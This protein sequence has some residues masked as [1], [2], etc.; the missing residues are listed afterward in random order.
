MDKI[1]IIRFMLVSIIFL[2]V[3]VD[4]IISANIKNLRVDSKAAD[5]LHTDAHRGGT[6]NAQN[7][8]VVSHSKTKLKHANEADILKARVNTDP[9]ILA[10]LYYY[11]TSGTPS[12]P[13]GDVRLYGYVKVR[14]P[15]SRTSSGAYKTIQGILVDVWDQ[16]SGEPYSDGYTPSGQFIISTRTDS[17]GAFCVV[18]D[19]FDWGEL[20]NR[21]PVLQFYTDISNVVA[22]YDPSN[23]VYLY[24]MYNDYSNL[25]GGAYSLYIQGSYWTDPISGQQLYKND[26]TTVSYV[27]PPQSIVYVLGGPAGEIML[28]AML[29]RDFA[30][31]V[32]GESS[33]PGLN[34]TYPAQ[35]SV[36][37]YNT[38]DKRLWAAAATNYTEFFMAFAQFLLAQRSVLPSFERN[39]NFNVHTDPKTAW[40]VGWSIFLSEVI[41]RY[42]ISS[43]NFE[44]RDLETLYDSDNSRNDFDVASSVAAVLWDLYDSSD[45]DQDGD[46]IGDSLSISISDIWYVVRTYKPTTIFEFINGLLSWRT[47]LSRT[48][49]WELCWEHGINV[50]F[51]PPTKPEIININPQPSS[52]KWYNTSNVY[53]AWS[54]STDSMSGIRCYMVRV[55][56]YSSGSL[57]NWYGPY[58]Q[59]YATIGLPSGVWSISVVAVD[60][61]GNENESARKGPIQIDTIAPRILSYSP[62][63]GTVFLDNATNNIVLSVVCSDQISGVERVLI[64]YSYGGTNWSDWIVASYIS[65]EFRIVISASEWKPHVGKKLYWE[66]KCIDKAGNAVISQRFYVELVDDDPNPPEIVFPGNYITIYDSSNEDLVIWAVITDQESGVG[67]VTF[68]VY[69]QKYNVAITYNNNSI[70]WNGNTAYIIIPR[71]IWINY[72]GSAFSLEVIAYDK[73]ND[74]QGDA[75]VARSFITYGEILDDDIDG[76]VIHNVSVSEYLSSGTGD[77]I[78]EADEGLS[79]RISVSDPSGVNETIVIKIY[80]IVLVKQAQV[81]YTNG[82][83]FELLLIIDT[84]LRAGDCDIEITIYDL[85]NDRESDSSFSVYCLRLSIREEEVIFSFN[86][87]EINAL[88]NETITIVF[89]AYR[90]DGGIIPLEGQKVY[91]NVYNSS[92]LMHTIEIYY[93]GENSQV[94]VDLASLHAPAGYLRLEFCL[95]DTVFKSKSNIVWVHVWLLTSITISLSTNSPVWSETVV[96]QIILV[97]M[98][99]DPVSNAYVYL[100]YGGEILAEGYTDRSGKAIINWAVNLPEGEYEIRV[101]F[102][103]D[104]VRSYYP[105]EI[106]VAVSVSKAHLVIQ[107]SDAT[108]VFSDGGTICANVST[109]LGVPVNAYAEVYVVI[110]DDIYLLGGNYSLSGRLVVRILSSSY[111]KWLTPGEYVYIIMIYESDKFYEASLARNLI[112]E[113]DVLKGVDISTNASIIEWGDSLLIKIHAFDDDYCSIVQGIANITIVSGNTVLC[114]ILEVKDGT[115]VLS[116]NTNMFIPLQ[117]IAIIVKV[118]SD[119]YV[120]EACYTYYV[121]VCKERA[122]VYSNSYT[123]T[124]TYQHSSELLILLTD[125]DGEEVIDDSGQVFVVISGLYTIYN[126]TLKPQIR[127]AYPFY[128]DFLPGTYYLEIQLMSNFYELVYSPKI[129]LVIE[130]IST[131]IIATLSPQMVEYGDFIEIY[132]I[133]IDQDNKTLAGIPISI[134]LSNGSNVKYP[135]VTT[136]TD[137]NGTA[138]IIVRMSFKPGEYVLIIQSSATSIHASSSFET[139]LTILEEDLNAQVYVPSV[140]EIGNAARIK[141]YITDNDNEPVAG[142]IVSIIVGD[143]LLVRTIYNGPL[144]IIW[145]PDSHG[146]HLIKVEV[147]GNGHYKDKSLSKLIEVKPAREAGLMYGLIVLGTFSCVGAI[148]VALRKFIARS[149]FSVHEKAAPVTGEISYEE[150][151]KEFLEIFESEELDL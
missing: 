125:N 68:I 25:G 48:K 105:S 102:D 85:D 64:R 148:F 75:A 99:G 29:A 104:S 74:W 20:S 60:R 4:P 7:V 11:I 19:A 70:Y 106:F 24:R 120:G 142:V 143:R 132:V 78:I 113:K 34:I 69:F 43:E 72:V 10:Y 3:I 122:M 119:L 116:V 52:T 32:L 6:K 44:L 88:A 107:S 100:S 35:T 40:V 111:P 123:W 21:D 15:Y 47:D 23:R 133:L 62:Q 96:A 90:N 137:E 95:N 131:E 53:I 151:E 41:K 146:E 126:G 127:L 141:V 9:V 109:E 139:Q 71:N 12:I 149:R 79:I 128:V 16:D 92:G 147:L 17:Q 73:D 80:S 36:Y 30:I 87:S 27:T 65:G 76:P 150:I 81:L 49:V 61:A 42:Y 110:N 98:F 94:V 50:D 115:A 13:S 33:L 63:I 144:E 38:T 54:Q 31:S 26:A 58:E 66:A 55:Y 46:G 145:V 37:F 103:G 134:Y 83:L 124:V 5:D 121:Y 117:Q 8:I 18:Y 82:T 1:Q 89:S 84:P 129:T 51:V 91:I 136:I 112:V 108:I 138:K 118:W 97:D 59:L 28:F 130:A 2:A 67:S 135:V 77:G 86:A 114:K 101:A 22:I 57:F 93:N 39:Y 14:D 45:D 140:L 56:N